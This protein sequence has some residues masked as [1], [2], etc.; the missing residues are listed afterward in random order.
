MERAVLLNS[1]VAM[2][3]RIGSFNRETKNHE[4]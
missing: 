3:G 4:Q 2:G 1:I